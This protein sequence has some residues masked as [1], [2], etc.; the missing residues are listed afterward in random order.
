MIF[1][2]S[3]RLMCWSHMIRRCRKHRNLVTKDD[4]IIIDKD[5]HTLQLAFSDE[6]F[7]HGARLLLQ[8]WSLIPTMN[9]FVQYF[10][11]QWLCKLRYWYAEN[12]L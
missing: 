6:I 8:K 11:E 9:R 1:P 7:D 2:R 5:I 4:W 3:R 12:F 10:T